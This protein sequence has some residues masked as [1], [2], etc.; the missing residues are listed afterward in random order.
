MLEIVAFE[1]LNRCQLGKAADILRTALDGPSYKGK[2]QAEAQVA[3]FL[4]CAERFALA[5]LEG[6]RLLGWIG[7]VRGYSRALELHPLVVDPD[8]QR[9]GVGRALVGALK[10]RAFLEGFL[11][12]HL[13]T[14]DWVGGTSLGGRPLFPNVLGKL[15]QVQS[16]GKGHAYFFYLKLGFEPV[17]LIPDANGPG[18]PDILM[19]KALT[20]E[21][22]TNS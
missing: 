16:R 17:G 8:S 1:S 14:D 20:G 4:E 5:A 22:S 15:E 18:L 6:N 12:L 13:G 3:T 9:Q 10:D 7:A 19:A 2:G 11:T 21:P